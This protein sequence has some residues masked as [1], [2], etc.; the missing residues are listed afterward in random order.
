MDE[1]LKGAEYLGDAV[2]VKYDGFHV[3][4]FTH[5]GMRM[6]DRIALDPEVYARLAQFVEQQQT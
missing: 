1:Q 3:W 5:D 4:L 2:Y 6:Q